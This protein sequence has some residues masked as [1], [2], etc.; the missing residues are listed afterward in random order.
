MKFKRVTSSKYIGTDDYTLRKG[1]DGSFSI[2]KGNAIT[3]WGT[4]FITVRSAEI[5]LDH[6]DYIKATTDKLPISSDDLE[7]L[8]EIYHFKEVSPGL[9]TAGNLQLKVPK[10]FDTSHV[11]YLLSASDETHKKKIL[12]DADSLFNAIDSYSTYSILGSINPNNSTLEYILAKKSKRGAG[13]AASRLKQSS[14]NFEK[15]QKRRTPQ[16]ITRNLIRVK[17]SNVWAYGVDIKDTDA[18]VG[19][20]YVQF[21]GKNGGPDGGI[22]VY[23]DVPIILWRKF[24]SAPSKGHFVYKY[25]RN[26][27]YYSKLTGDKRGKLSNAINH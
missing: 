7:A 22:Y 8:K 24:I 3:K 17:S 18:K 13:G 6:H 4:G 15:S 1:V 2:F 23:Y 16:E 12:S 11:V 19:D 21:K 27:F 14:S 26:N 10:D 9:F 25:L 5:F 20:V